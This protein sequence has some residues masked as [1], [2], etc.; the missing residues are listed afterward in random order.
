MP[1][2]ESLEARVR[3]LLA[4]RADV[5]EMEMMGGHQFLVGGRIS[6]SVRADTLSVRIAP[7]DRDRALKLPHVVPMTIGARTAKGFVRVGLAG[8]RTDAQLRSWVERGVH[9]ALARK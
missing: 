1:S 2:T 4:G 7:E 6:V 3:A 9:A 8:L 5:S